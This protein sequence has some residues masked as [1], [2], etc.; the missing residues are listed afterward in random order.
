MAN[1]RPN[2]LRTIG[3]LLIALGAIEAVT[4]AALLLWP[5]DPHSW[6]PERSTLG[7]LVGAMGVVELALGIFLFGRST[8]KARLTPLTFLAPTDEDRVVEAIERFEKRTSGE[9]RVHL[10]DHVSGEILTTAKRT[11]ERL[12]LTATRE[13]NGVLFFVVVRDHKFAVLGDEGIHRK[14]PEG[15]WSDV[16]ARVQ[17]RFA[18]GAFAQGLVEGIE[19][20]GEQLATHFP[21]RGDDTNELPNQISR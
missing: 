14:V 9:L 19:L 20:A 2:A 5:H 4:G 16:A 13:R 1:G 10:E 8:A 11:F 18:Q 6:D 12:G 17:Q 3:L 7:Y 21:P 15:F